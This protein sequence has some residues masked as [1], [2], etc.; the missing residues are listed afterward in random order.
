[1]SEPEPVTS[2]IT[3]VPEIL[4]PKDPDFPESWFRCSPEL[5]SEY[6]TRVNAGYEEL[7]KKTA[8]ICGLARN[9]EHTLPRTLNR[10]WQFAQ[11]FKDHRFVIVENDSLDQTVATLRQWCG[12]G[13]RRKL[14]TNDFGAPSWPQTPDARRMRALALC[15]EMY[16]QYIE[17]NWSTYDLVVVH[18]LDLSDGFSFDGIAHSVMEPEWDMIGSN[19]ISFRKWREHPRYPVF[20]D[21]W[22]YREFGH[23][24]PYVVTE[25]MNGRVYHRGS[26][27]NPVISCF[28]GLGMYKMRSF[29]CGAAYGHQNQDGGAECEHVVFHTEMARRNCGRILFNPSQ[30]CL[31]SP[32]HE[33]TK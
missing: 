24:Q 9:L 1:M 7:K 26:P 10:L 3:R 15:R 17:Y 30:V 11:L 29:L 23:P 4:A 27:L 2:R 12:L 13:N 14:I 6:N 32:I 21:I 33:E 16:R 28:G 5:M 31:Y 22:A 25:N 20:F 18:D 8:V 19:G